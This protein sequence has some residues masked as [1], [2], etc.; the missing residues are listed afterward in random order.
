MDMKIRSLED[1]YLFSLPIKES[2]II[3]F[4]LVAA[5][6]DEVLKIMAVQKQTCAGQC[7]R[8]KAFVAIEDYNRHVGLG[9]LCCK[10][11]TTTIGGAI[12]LVKLSIVSLWRGYL[13][14]KIGKPTSLPHK[15]TSYCSSML[16]AQRQW[17]HL[18]FSSQKAAANGQC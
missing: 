6:K 11:V 9:V 8:F 16:V 2:E 10:E 12:I 1:I 3:A 14:N 7:T 17:H 4:F 15:V 18:S 5:L 13:G